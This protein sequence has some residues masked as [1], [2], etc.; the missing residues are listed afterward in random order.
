MIRQ[1]PLGKKVYG[2]IYVHKKYITSMVNKYKLFPREFPEMCCYAM[3]KANIEL[4]D[5]TIL[6][7]N[8]REMKISFIYCPVFDHF[9]T[10]DIEGY[11]TVNLRTGRVTRRRY[12]I[13]QNRPIY[14]HK[15][16]MV[17]NSYPGFLVGREQLRS[18]LVEK[19]IK[20]FPWIDKKMIGYM[21]YWKLE[22]VPKLLEERHDPLF[23]HNT[24]EAADW[25]DKEKIR[26]QNV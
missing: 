25:L 22:V 1:I 12:T 18:M 5:F 6:K 10:P 7:F 24:E 8:E 3:E 26:C 14:H 2:S 15:W 17:E 20:M 11:V 4:S 23:F 9:P 21:D 13:G 19:V 16:L